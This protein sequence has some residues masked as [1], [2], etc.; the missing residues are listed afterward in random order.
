MIASCIYVVSYPFCIVCVRMPREVRIG[1]IYV[2]MLS[3]QTA[4]YTKTQIDIIN[5][6]IMVGNIPTFIQKTI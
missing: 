1:G 3:F 5:K 2:R 6:Q 4:I